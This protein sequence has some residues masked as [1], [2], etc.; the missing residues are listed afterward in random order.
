MKKNILFFVVA[1]V[2]TTTYSY[3]QVLLPTYSGDALRF[4][5]S[6]YGST[7]RFKGMGGAQI[8][9][10]GDMSSLSGNPAGWPITNSGASFAIL[11]VRFNFN[12]VNC[13]IT[14]S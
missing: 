9:V 3:A 7:A 6:N 12:G 10:G 11:P 1:M 13:G 5:Q 2:A 8:G 4:S 14:M